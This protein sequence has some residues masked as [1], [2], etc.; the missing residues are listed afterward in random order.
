MLK[1]RAFIAIAILF[2]AV[3]PSLAQT[4]STTPTT[5]QLITLNF[6]E[7]LELKVLIDYV[8]QRLGVNILYDEQQVNQRLG[9]NILYDEQQVNQRHLELIRHATSLPASPGSNA[10]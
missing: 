9:V 6:P 8:S 1:G 4:P 5:Q 10:T 2:I 7:N 3:Q